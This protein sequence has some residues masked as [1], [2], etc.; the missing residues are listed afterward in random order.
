[1]VLALNP[2]PFD[3]TT[4]PFVRVASLLAAMPLPVPAILDHA[5]DLG[6]LSLQDL[7]DVTLQAYLGAVPPDE[8]VELYRQAVSFIEI[9]QR[10]GEDLASPDYPSYGIAFDVEKLL[11]ELEFFTKHFI[12][13]YQ[14]ARIDPAGARHPD[15]R[16]GRHWRRTSRPSRGCCATATITAAT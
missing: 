3:F 16:S 15:A 9:M 12:E 5:D 6:V 10:R 2:E 11:W 8:H 1:M 4:L 14:G 7:G 13:G